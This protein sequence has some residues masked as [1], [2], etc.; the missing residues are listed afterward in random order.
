MAIAVVAREPQVR[1]LADE[2][3]VETRPRKHE[4]SD[5]PTFSI[6]PS[7]LVYSSTLNPA[8]R[9]HTHWS[10]GQISCMSAPR[11]SMT[12]KRPW[13]LPVN[14]D[15]FLDHRF[16]GDELDVIPGRHVT[17]FISSSARG[18]RKIFEPGWPRLARLIVLA[19]DDSSRHDEDGDVVPGRPIECLG[20]ESQ[21]A[22]ADIERP[23]ES[24][25]V[26]QLLAGCLLLGTGI[27]GENAI[28][29]V[30]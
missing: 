6:V 29:P 28:A 30:R 23:V 14:Q 26:I 12:H 24:G 27:S 8:D 7:F 4:C 11:S 19:G 22:S 3:A 9:L 15:G 5:L 13:E 21:L 25:R 1:R 20:T 17:A 16:A 10:R 18:Q 2:D